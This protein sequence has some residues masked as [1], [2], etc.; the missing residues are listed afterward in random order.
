MP[1]PW[2]EV[3][4]RI[5]RRRYE[6]LRF[7]VGAVLGAEGVLILDTRASAVQAQEL[8]ADLRKLTNL[9]VRWVV[10]THYHWDH[11]WG[12][13]EFAGIPIWGHEECRN[14]MAEVDDA[15]IEATAHQFAEYADELRGLTIVPPDR[16]FTE[17]DTID[18]GGRSVTMRY[19]GLGHTNSDIVTTVSDSDVVFAGDLIEEGTPPWFGDSFPLE[20][21][22]TVERLLPAVRGLA[23]PGHGGVMSPGEVGTQF[24]ELR[25][26][27]RVIRMVQAGD[28]ARDAAIV[29]GPYPA[30]VMRIAL[31]RVFGE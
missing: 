29:A 7:N 12:N 28:M 27:A 31:G 16:V 6:A 1:A 11:T 25:E 22:D 20:W 8:L 9:P 15:E 13:C 14:V 2:D 17:A 19:L 3:G 23:V 21:P 4:D 24:E 10:N 5:F 30:D 18:I 26:V